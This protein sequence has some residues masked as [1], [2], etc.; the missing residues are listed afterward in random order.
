MSDHP[1]HPDE[2]RPSAQTENYTNLENLH[3]R[4]LGGHTYIV[5]SERNGTETAYQVDIGSLTCPCEDMEYNTEGHEVCA[6]LY[7]AILVAPKDR[8]LGTIASKDI[9]TLVGRMESVVNRA[10]S[11]GQPTQPTQATGGQS[12]QS[13]G[14][15]QQTAEAETQEVPDNVLEP[16]HEWM[17]ENLAPSIQK[18]LTVEQATHGSMDGVKIEPDYREISDSQKETMKSAIKS[19]GSLEYHVGFD[20]P[21]DTCG[22]DDGS[23]WYFIPAGQIPKL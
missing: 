6:H 22:E 21:C 13:N 20:G 7:K 3:A 19:I 16:V 23:F 4:P 5:A 9:A 14:G 8:E 2:P 11:A 18:G 15:S 1:T 17:D 12:G 10:E